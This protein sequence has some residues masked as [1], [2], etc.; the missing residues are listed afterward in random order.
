MDISVGTDIIEIS[1]LNGPV[2]KPRFLERVFSER[3]CEYVLRKGGGA[4]RTAAG[5]FAA[6]EAFGKAVGTGVFPNTLK[7]IE[8][9]HD[10]KGKPYLELG[11]EFAEIYRGMKFCVSIS[12]C[13]H[14]AV[15][16][17]IAYK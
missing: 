14:Y 15:A 9:L 16:T 3:E 11:G 1:R 17:V 7:I 8:I 12:H 13:E 5:I 6:K 4:A 10:E 2:S